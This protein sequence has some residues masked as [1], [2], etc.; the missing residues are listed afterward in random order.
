[1]KNKIFSLLLLLLFVLGISLLV[2]NQEGYLFIENRQKKVFNHIKDDFSF[3]NINSVI[4][5]QV[6][7]RDN[8][9]KSFLDIYNN[10]EIGNKV[11][12]YD[13]NQI[14]INDMFLDNSYIRQSDSILDTVA[15]KAFNINEI[16]NKYP[17]IKTYVYNPGRYLFEPILNSV[18]FPNNYEIFENTF[19]YYL[20]EK[21]KYKKLEYQDSQIDYYFYKTDQH[22][23]VYGADKVYRDVI[24]MINE[25]FDVGAPKELIDI[26][27]INK[28]F[29]GSYSDVCENIGDIY[30]V[31]ADGNYGINDNDF[32]YYINDKKL[33]IVNEKESTIN[34]NLYSKVRTYDAYYNSNAGIMTFDFCDESKENILIITDSYIGPIKEVLSSHF[35]KSIIVSGDYGLEKL[36]LDDTIKENNISIIL[37]LWF[38]QNLYYNGYYFIPIN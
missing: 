38:H 9:I 34:D 31:F 11:V 25:D 21:V 37:I 27:E 22:L 14:K 32:D 15:N 7:N 16:S 29:R 30:D 24:D 19:T 13:R 6:F 1:M 3:E 23:N 2:K 20:G 5:D 33:S 12:C 10:F 17:E 35:N 26:K 4:G 18:W 8:I 28:E 36:R